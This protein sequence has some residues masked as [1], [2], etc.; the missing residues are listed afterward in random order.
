[1]HPTVIKSYEDGTIFKYIEKLN[2]EKGIKAAE[3][4]TAEKALLKILEH[5]KLAEAS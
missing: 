4:N 3:L 2:E 5:E 1:V